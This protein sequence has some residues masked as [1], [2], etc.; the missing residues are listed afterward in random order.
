MG[1]KADEITWA[2]IRGAGQW[3]PRQAKWVIAELKRSGLSTK[4]FSA[5]YRVGLP[6]IY[7]WHARFGAQEKAKPAPTGLVEVRMPQA[8]ARGDQRPTLARARIE[9]EL[10]S[11]RRLRVLETVD[12]GRLGALVALLERR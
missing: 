3:S 2:D 5:R 7:Y 11:G 9:I 8:G 1:K 6:R 10:L 12:L 4:R